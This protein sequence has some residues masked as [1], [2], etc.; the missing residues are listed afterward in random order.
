MKVSR[1]TFLKSTATAGAAAAVAGGLVENVFSA[2]PALTPGPGNKWPGKVA[3]NFNKAAVTIDGTNATPDTAVIQKMVDDTI[4]LLT[5]ESTVGAA[6]KAVF[7]ASLSA[8]S[9]IAIK[10]NTLNPGLPAPHWS[11]VKAITDGLQQMDVGGGKFPA[12]GIVIYEAV[13]NNLSDAGLGYNATNFGTIKISDDTDNLV[14]GGDG[15][16]NKRTYAKTLKD[17]NF[18]INVFSPRGHMIMVCSTKFTL[19]FKSHFG[20]YSAPTGLHQNSNTETGVSATNLRDINCTGPVFNKTVLSVCSGI[21]GKK[22]GSGPTGLADSY[23]NYAKTMDS[24]LTNSNQ[25]PTTI[26]M[27]TDPVSIEMQTIKMM[28]LNASP[29]GKYGVAD[30]PTYL[31]ASAGVTGVLSGTTYNIGQIDETKMDIKRLIND[32]VIIE[33]A[34]PAI[35]GSNARLSA[36]PIKGRNGTFIEFKLPKA[37][38]GNEAVLEIYD[39]KGTVVRKLS[40]KVLG[41]LNHLSWDNRDTSGAPIGAG[42]YIVRLTAGSVRLSAALTVM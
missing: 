30:M 1:R 6:W 4:K 10:V 2:S 29:A 22:E 15:A 12:S 17:A 31:R 13:G 25:P 18:L 7:P 33:K 19:G 32:S 3:I 38:I 20:T 37:Q 41:V 27:S 34:Q 28:R 16:L 23:L 5:G 11:S 35:L 21:F 40:Q 39:F 8:Q 26:M 36:I 24:S 42:P 14:D 9:I